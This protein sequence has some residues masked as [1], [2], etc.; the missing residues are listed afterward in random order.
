MNDAA[1]NRRTA[2]HAS[3]DNHCIKGKGI[4]G[5][6]LRVRLDASVN[7][8][9]PYPIKGVLVILEQG[10]DLSII[11]AVFHM[12]RDDGSLGPPVTADKP[13]FIYNPAD[14]TIARFAYK[15]E[16]QRSDAMNAARHRCNAMCA[17]VSNNHQW[18][19]VNDQHGTAYVVERTG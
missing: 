1:T 7:E 2:Y 11:K 15:G 17:V 4:I 13:V 3:L 12:E 14:C 8:C 6:G 18:R 5:F 10:T 9:I 19:H 16:A